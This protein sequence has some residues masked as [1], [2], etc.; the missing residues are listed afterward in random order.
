[1]AILI[2]ILKV[3]IAFAITCAVEGFYPKNIAGFTSYHFESYSH[4][5][6]LI[7]LLTSMMASSFGMSKFFVTGPISIFPNERPLDGMFS[8]QFICV[9]LLNTM[10][11][12]RLVCIENAFFTTY[13]LSNKMKPYIP[14][15][16]KEDTI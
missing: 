3:H 11:G 9:L 5:L 12:W 10:F 15:Q 1:M 8:Y 4:A 6:P 2:S 7:S 16:Y 14:N 13:R